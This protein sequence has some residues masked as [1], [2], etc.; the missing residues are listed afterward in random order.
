MNVPQLEDAGVKKELGFALASEATLLLFPFWTTV[1]RWDCGKCSHCAHTTVLD[2]MQK[3]AVGRS[4][5]L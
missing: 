4:L 2:S 1:S 5:G 3:T